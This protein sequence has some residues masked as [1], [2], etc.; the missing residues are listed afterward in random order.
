MEEKKPFYKTAE[1]GKFYMRE[2]PAEEEKNLMRTYYPKT[3][4]M[5]QAMVEDACDRLDYEGSFLYDE[6]PDKWSIERTCQRIESRME[7]QMQSVS[8]N[9][10]GEFIRILFCQE[11]YQRRCRRKRCR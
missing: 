5:I 3:A 9:L 4:G 10:L 11:M 2:A 1:K 8:E 7:M 6:Y